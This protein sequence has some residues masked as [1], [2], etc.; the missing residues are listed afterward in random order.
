MYMYIVYMHARLIPL[1]FYHAYDVQVVIQPSS[2]RA[3]T[4]RE[5]E[6]AG[7]VINDDLSQADTIVGE[8]VLT[9]VWFALY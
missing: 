2:R 4:M 7:A 3:Y 1:M 5:Y 8:C 9:C 6:K